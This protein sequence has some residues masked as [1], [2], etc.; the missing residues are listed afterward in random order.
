MPSKTPN[1]LLA[2]FI[3]EAALARQLDVDIR[4]VQRWK[5]LGLGP[6]YTMV[7]RRPVY[8]LEAV[9]AWLLS[10]EKKP[11]RERAGRRQSLTSIRI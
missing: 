7:G 5:A 11:P 6:P 4:S 3:S 8:R 9:R 1:S 10:R 2:D